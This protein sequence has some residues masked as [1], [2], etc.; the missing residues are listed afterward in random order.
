M[1]VL[2]TGATGLVGQE[3][4]NRCMKQGV[5]VHYL[6]RSKS[7]LSSDA[8]YKGFYWDVKNQEIDIA[9]FEGV[10]TIIHLAGATISKR[11]T[12]SYKQ[13]ILDSRV[14]S[15]RLLKNTIENH[16]F[17]IRH[18]I[19]ASA[20]GIYPSSI[21]NYYEENFPSVSNTFLG[22]VVEQW[23]AAVDELSTLNCLISKVRIG[24]VLS[25]KDGALPQ[26]VKPI[27]L[28]LGA[29]F[30]SGEQWQS[31]IHIK[32]LAGIF[33]FIA[34]NQLEGVFNGVAPNAVTNNELTKAAAQVLEKPLFLPN[35]PSVLMHAILGEMAIIL[36][37]SQ[38][39]SSK[40][41]EEEGFKYEFPNLRPAL[42]D[43]LL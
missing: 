1:T 28:G 2:I 30:G 6:S 4:V 38:R 37:E 41:I 9:C 17:P 29:P 18:F 40:K 10:S 19:S 12:K 43:L 13:E 15:T 3:I 16:Q 22:E 14:N 7:K 20:I 5:T 23:E 31:W 27:K 42:E 39:V 33:L 35:V 26:I 34:Q 11:W 36:F 25:D 24:L 8:S 21:T 32:D